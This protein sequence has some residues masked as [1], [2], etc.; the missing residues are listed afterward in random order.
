MQL[1]ID[2]VRYITGKIY[3]KEYVDKPLTEI[4]S[5]DMFANHVDMNIKFYMEAKNAFNTYDIDESKLDEAA[6]IVG[7]IFSVFGDIKDFLTGNKLVK[8]FTKLMKD[9][10]KKLLKKF[11]PTIEKMVDERSKKFIHDASDMVT[12]FT[13]W[14]YKTFS[15]EGLAKMFAMIKY[16]TLRPT[17][18]MIKCTKTLALKSYRVILITLVSVFLIKFVTVASVYMAGKAMV[19]SLEALALLFSKIGAGSVAKGI[20]STISA[21]I[22]GK[23]ISKVSKKI[24]S[25]LDSENEQSMGELES[26]WNRKCSV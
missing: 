25:Q 17:S 2:E 7:T 5:S 22:K 14:M 19:T 16:K 20:F 18:E 10:L 12:K 4:I 24:K 21:V 23:D 15:Y 9:L 8:D 1:T 6:G 13:E 26:E 11:I 3:E